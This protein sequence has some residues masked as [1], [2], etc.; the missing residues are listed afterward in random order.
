MAVLKS[1]AEGQFQGQDVE[2]PSD[3]ATLRISSKV[4]SVSASGHG[5]SVAAMALG[6][7][8]PGTTIAVGN[9]TGLGTSSVV[10]I[11]LVQIVMATIAV[12]LIAKWAAGVSK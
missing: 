12:A 6:I 5:A 8:G 11:S 3:R 9:S 1:T 7:A 4:V 2:R 10:L